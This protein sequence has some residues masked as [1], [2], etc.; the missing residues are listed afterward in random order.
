MIDVE[1]ERGD[2]IAREVELV[3]VHADAVAATPRF[4]RCVPPWSRWGRTTGPAFD[5]PLGALIGMWRRGKLVAPLRATGEPILVLASVGSALSGRGWFAGLCRR[6][7][8]VVRGRTSN[9]IDLLDI[10]PGAISRSYAEAV[11]LI[12]QEKPAGPTATYDEVI[13]TLHDLTGRRRP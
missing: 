8:R 11:V 7:G 6:S 4:A 13:R 1:N 10:E 12:N 5:L 2:T 9:G 3:L